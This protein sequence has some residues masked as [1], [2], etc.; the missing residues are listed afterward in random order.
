MLPARLAV[1]APKHSASG[2]TARPDGRE[3][4]MRG[5]RNNLT[6]ASVPL[7]DDDTRFHDRF[8]LPIASDIVNGIAA[9]K[10]DIGV[11]ADL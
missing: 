8:D 5:P 1:P 2:R 3:L 7:L 9:N 4:P 10:H 11:F 6:A